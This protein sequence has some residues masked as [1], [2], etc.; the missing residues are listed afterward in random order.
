[1]PETSQKEELKQRLLEKFESHQTDVDKSTSEKS[2][3]DVN[4]KG[5]TTPITTLVLKGIK[6]MQQQ[7]D[8]N[9]RDHRKAAKAKC[10]AEIRKMLSEMDS[11]SDEDSSGVNKCLGVTACKSALAAFLLIVPPTPS[12]AFMS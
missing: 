12:Q 1:M 3:V 8:F 5:H 4:S 10:K 9:S 7:N 6:P 2:K 11:S